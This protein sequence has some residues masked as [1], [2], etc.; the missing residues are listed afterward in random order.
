MSTDE[1]VKWDGPITFI[2]NSQSKVSV[3]AT[4]KL[5]AVR[6][7]TKSDTN[8]TLSGLEFEIEQGGRRGSR[9]YA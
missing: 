1:P 3:R 8:W 5:L 2:P 7:E 6:F 4:G 9:V